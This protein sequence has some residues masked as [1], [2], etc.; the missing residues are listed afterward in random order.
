MVYEKCRDRRRE[1]SQK[2]IK[3]IIG[4]LN[5]SSDN[6]S[7]ANNRQTKRKTNQPQPYSRFIPSPQLPS[8]CSSPAGGAT[9]FID[10]M[11]HAIGKTICLTKNPEKT[12]E[13]LPFEKGD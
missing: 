7:W 11:T 1:Y 4:R 6:S 5:F 12:G 8:P 9:P 10:F 2:K 3:I 13:T